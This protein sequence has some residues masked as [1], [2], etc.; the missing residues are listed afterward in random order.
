MSKYTNEFKLEVV[1]HYIEQNHGYESTAKHFKI[2]T[3]SLVKLWVRKYKKHGV[4]GL[5]RNH[6]KFDGNFK[7]NVLEYMHKNHLSFFETAV[8]FN[9][10]CAGVVSEWER[11]YYEKGSQALFKERRGGNRNNMSNSKKKIEVDLVVENEKLRMENAYLKKLDALVQERI[12]RENKK[13]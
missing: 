8:H 9:I 10:G 13:K 11:I 4:N 5:I 12:K 2:A 6:I 7:I 1:K 3:I